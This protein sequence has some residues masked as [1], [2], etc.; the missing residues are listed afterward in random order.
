MCIKRFP[1]NAVESESDR[2][3]QALHVRAFC[4]RSNEGRGVFVWVYF[5]YQ[6]Y[7]SE[8]PYCTINTVLMSINGDISV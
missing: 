1:R 2:A 8:I 3:P 4:G 5:K 7:F 6:Q